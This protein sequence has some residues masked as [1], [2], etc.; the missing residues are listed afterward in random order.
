M[1]KN[2]IFFVV[3]NTAKSLKHILQ[4]REFK[5]IEYLDVIITS[6]RGAIDAKCSQM[7]L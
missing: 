7:A 2:G 6:L 5:N 3:K 1:T 4:C